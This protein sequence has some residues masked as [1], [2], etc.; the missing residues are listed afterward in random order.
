MGELGT[1]HWKSSALPG[2]A[3]Q[4]HAWRDGLMKEGDQTAFT[5]FLFLVLFI[6]S[7]CRG[8][9]CCRLVPCTIRILY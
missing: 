5:R 8:D 9:T 4:L 1:L 2:Q 7:L 3:K 6:P